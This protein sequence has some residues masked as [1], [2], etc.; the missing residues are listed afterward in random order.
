MPQRCRRGCIWRAPAARCAV[1]VRADLRRRGRG[2]LLGFRRAKRP[3]EERLARASA[4]ALGLF[5]R[6]S[7]GN[8]FRLGKWAWLSVV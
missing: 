1:R 3:C 7:L 4:R 5:L 2:A 8:F 6:R